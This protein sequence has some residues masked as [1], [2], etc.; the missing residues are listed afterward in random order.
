M[1]ASKAGRLR[2]LQGVRPD[3]V[4]RAREWERQGARALHVVDLDGAKEGSPVQLDL[5]RAIAT[6][7]SI[8]V[9]TGGGVRS[10]RDLESLTA[11][12][13]ARVV[14]GTAAV[15]DRDLRRR[16]VELVDEALVVAADARDGVVATH[17]WQRGSGVEALDLARELAA[18]SVSS[19][20]YTDVGR[21]G[22]SAGAALEDTAAIAR[23]VPTI[24]SGG[25][26]D[27]EDLAA[28][29]RLPGVV[30]AIV[31]T[32]LYEG[33]ATLEELLAAVR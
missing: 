15:G 2:A 21:D 29:S 27:A 11:A 33:S 8:P 3:P 18:D 28:L 22:M 19:V 23:I 31:G 4:S 32:A 17:G 16:A 12:G 9:Q 10:L 25:V 7:V 5:I 6:A 14:M 24:A 20:L 13:A 26:R 30:G 1:R